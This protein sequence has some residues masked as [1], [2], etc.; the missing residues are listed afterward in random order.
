MNIDRLGIMEM[1]DHELPPVDLDGGEGDVLA[2]LYQDT[3]RT[4]E[5]PEEEA[6]EEDREDGE[7]EL[8]L[9]ES[10]EP[11]EIEEAAKEEQDAPVD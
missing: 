8:K 10:P 11:E 2:A 5:A 4:I 3:E 6:S 7:E 9:L 1:V